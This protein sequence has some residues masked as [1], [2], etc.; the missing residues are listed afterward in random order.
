MVYKDGKLLTLMCKIRHLFWDGVLLL[1]FSFISHHTDTHNLRLHSSLNVSNQVS[2]PYR[3][4]GKSVRP[5]T[6][7]VGNRNRHYLSG[8]NTMHR[9]NE[10]L[11]RKCAETGGVPSS[12]E[13]TYSHRNR[14]AQGFR[15][16]CLCMLLI[17]SF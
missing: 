6:A 15:N 17:Q 16:E 9:H 10:S 5:V 13:C 2:H 11:T 14:L 12:E 3:T 1:S 7:I 8:R 4:T